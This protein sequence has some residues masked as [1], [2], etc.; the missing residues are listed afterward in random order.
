MRKRISI[1]IAITLIVISVLMVWGIPVF[2]QTKLATVI[3]GH[4]L[5][6]IAAA[7]IITNS[8]L[9]IEKLEDGTTNSL[10]LC[11]D[12][13]DAYRYAHEQ[14]SAKGWYRGISDDH[15]PLLIAM[16]N[17]IEK[18]GYTSTQTILQDKSAEVLQKFWYASDTQNAVELGYASL[19]DMQVTLLDMT[20]AVKQKSMLVEGEKL[21]PLNP[22]SQESIDLLKIAIDSKWK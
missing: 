2:A 6:A 12:Y 16:V 1:I 20:N 13:V 21:I 19:E 15:T 22:V 9:P 11:R 14:L 8:G 4:P 7:Q 3:P 17:A 10:T 18:E 5:S